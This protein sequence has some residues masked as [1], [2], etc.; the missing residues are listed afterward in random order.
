MATHELFHTIYQLSRELTKQTNQTLQSF[1]LYSAQWAVLFVLKEKGSMPQSD[2]CEYLA[3]EAP[4]MTRTIQRL[5]KQDYVQQKPGADKR[6][7][8][9]ELTEKAKKAYPEW[10]QAVLSMNERLLAGV[11]DEQRMVMKTMLA[12]WL[13][14]LKGVSHE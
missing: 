9:I 3:V 5:M 4:P 10:E 7:K 1:G 13:V 8:M 6:V 14:T 12:S 2:L 11:P